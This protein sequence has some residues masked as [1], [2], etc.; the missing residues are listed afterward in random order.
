MG[1]SHDVLQSLDQ[2]SMFTRISTFVSFHFAEQPQCSGRTSL[3][4][5]ICYMAKE[6]AGA[7]H[8]KFERHHFG[9]V[10]LTLTTSLLLTSFDI[11]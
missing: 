1:C 8:R 4:R 3:Q 6:Q 2:Q 9:V 7:T 11:W 10:L 5:Y